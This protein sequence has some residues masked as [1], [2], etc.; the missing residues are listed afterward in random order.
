MRVQLVFLA[1]MSHGRC[2]VEMLKEVSDNH[3]KQ[4][5]NDSPPEFEDVETDE[6]RS[7]R[8][9]T[10]MR[11]LTFFPQQDTNC[12]CN[13]CQVRCKLGW[14]AAA[15]GGVWLAGFDVLLLGWL[16]WLPG[17]ALAC[18]DFAV[19]PARMRVRFNGMRGTTMIFRSSSPRATRAA[20][21][22]AAA[23]LPHRQ[24]AAPRPHTA[25]HARAA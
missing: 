8:A 3:W 6:G 5:R 1:G 12:S 7:C 19:R 23:A 11:P 9:C 14:P 25:Q 21:A 18:H 16:V 10:N 13:H 22:A 20:A 24:R 15:L 4:H 17:C 2:G